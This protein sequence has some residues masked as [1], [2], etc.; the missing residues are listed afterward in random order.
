M[1]LH[2]TSNDELKG[3]HIM[4]ARLTGSILLTALVLIPATAATAH[5]FTASA[6]TATKISG[7]RETFTVNAGTVGCEKST[8][9]G[10]ATAGTNIQTLVVNLTFTE[11]EAFGDAAKISTPVVLLLM[12]NEYADLLENAVLTVPVAKCS[13][14]VTGSAVGSGTTNKSLKTIKFTT[15]AKGIEV[16]A[17]VKGITY[18]SSGG[19]CGTAKTASHNGVDVGT[20]LIEPESGTLSWK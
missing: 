5:E 12:A 16:T 7:G 6:T 13:I 4:R 2:L 17:N 18:E 3:V 19:I 20:E 14:L 10:S 9:T 15:A 1:T 8:G 11:C